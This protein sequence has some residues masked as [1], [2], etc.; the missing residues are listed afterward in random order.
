MIIKLVFGVLGRERARS[1]V[2]AL[3]WDESMLSIKHT[4][5]SS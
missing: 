1:Y 5:V 2:I 4:Y 3:L